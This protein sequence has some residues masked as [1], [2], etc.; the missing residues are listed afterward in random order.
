[1]NSSVIIGGNDGME[2]EGDDD[3]GSAS[4]PKC[5]KSIIFPRNVSSVIKITKKK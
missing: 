1:M 2:E 5:K 3:I 4:A